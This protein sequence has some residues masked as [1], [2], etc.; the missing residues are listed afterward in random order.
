MPACPD[1]NHC[2][3]SFAQPKGPSAVPRTLGLP[4]HLRAF[5]SV[6]FLPA[7][8]FSWPINNLLPSGLLRK[9]I[10]CASLGILSPVAASLGS[11]V[12]LP[13]TW[14]HVT[15]HT[16]LLRL[17]VWVLIVCLPLRLQAPGGQGLS[18]LCPGTS[19]GPCTSWELGKYVKEGR[20]ETERKNHPSH[21]VRGQAR[22]SQELI[23][24]HPWWVQASPWPAGI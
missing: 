14:H 5:A 16:L 24:R 20:K 8:L 11:S 17:R 4:P 12:F 15:H 23:S 9:T 10:P 13:W 2:S 6:G 3:L 22:C 19:P 21:Q 18:A 7:T 1:V